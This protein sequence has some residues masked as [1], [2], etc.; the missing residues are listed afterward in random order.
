MIPT[1]ARVPLNLRIVICIQCGS[2]VA[3]VAPPRVS[4]LFARPE[5]ALC[6]LPGRSI[7]WAVPARAS[8][9]CRWRPTHRRPPRRR[10]LH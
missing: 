8:Q 10:S 1:S 7:P 6:C 5:L 3:P 9:R 4:S 2:N